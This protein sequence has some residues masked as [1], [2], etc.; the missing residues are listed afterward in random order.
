M[1]ETQDIVELQKQADE[2]LAACNIWRWCSIYIEIALLK[3]VIRRS[4]DGCDLAAKLMDGEGNDD[5]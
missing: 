5:E 2:A 4:K 3:G 1:P